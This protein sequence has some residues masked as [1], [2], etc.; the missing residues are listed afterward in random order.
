M[1]N[2]Y[3]HKQIVIA[4]FLGTMTLAQAKM[5]SD[6]EDNLKPIGDASSFTDGTG[7]AWDI[8]NFYHYNEKEYRDETPA[9][10]T[11]ENTA[12]SGDA[13]DNEAVKAMK[14]G[15]AEA[16][17]NVAVQAAREASHHSLYQ[18]RNFQDGTSLYQ[19]TDHPYRKS[20]WTHDQVDQSNPY[21]F[22]EETLNPTGYQF[23]D[24]K[25]LM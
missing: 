17:F 25:A 10:Y 8:E 7:K 6:Y 15:E 22:H 12:F 19:L 16:R 20:A 3:L 14:H 21:T 5:A 24:K 11:N 2:N 9:E 1:N 13:L 18:V 4:V 23:K